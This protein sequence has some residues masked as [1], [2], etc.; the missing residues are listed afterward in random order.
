MMGDFATEY[1]RVK[2]NILDAHGVALYKGATMP[3]KKNSDH[4]PGTLKTIPTGGKEVVVPR[5]ESD[6]WANDDHETVQ[7]VALWISQ[8]PHLAYSFENPYLADFRSETPRI[9]YIDGAYRPCILLGFCHDHRGR[10]PCGI[11]ARTQFVLDNPVPMH[12]SSNNIV[13]WDGATLRTERLKEIYDNLKPEFKDIITPVQKQTHQRNNIGGFIISKDYLWVESLSEVE[14]RAG[15][16]L[17]GI[18]YPYYAY[19]G[20]GTGGRTGRLPEGTAVRKWLR[21][22]MLTADHS[23]SAVN[24]SGSTGNIASNNAE[25]FFSVCFSI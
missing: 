16:T 14:G 12:I 25:T 4:L 6:G 24:A 1:Q 2:D 10:I 19:I 20:T 9:E 13:G 11:T 8:N 3:S 23:F 15:F 5:P 21:N 7:N 22:P 17:D 18:L